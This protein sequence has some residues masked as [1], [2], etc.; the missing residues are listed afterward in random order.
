MISVFACDCKHGP[1]GS[2][3]ERGQA[4]R[5]GGAATETSLK[6]QKA[7][8]DRADACPTSVCHSSEVDNEEQ[9]NN[10]NN[11]NNLSPNDQNNPSQLDTQ[12]NYSTSGSDNHDQQRHQQKDNCD[13]SEPD[14][15]NV[16]NYDSSDD[17]DDDD[18][19]APSDQLRQNAFAFRMK[20][21]SSAKMTTSSQELEESKECK[22]KVCSRMRI[23]LFVLIM[24]GASGRITCLAASLPPERPYALAVKLARLI[25]RELA[26]CLFSRWSKSHVLV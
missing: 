26:V 23:L 9:D 4:C 7:A 10:N 16:D 13:E 20:L 14:E 17:D 5:G 21:A 1:N 22:N 2:V 3:S 15:S 18:Q 25:R 24:I 19:E 8:C 12:D 6:E 11:N